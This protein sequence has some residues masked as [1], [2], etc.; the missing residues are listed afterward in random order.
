MTSSAL[1]LVEVN[2]FYGRSQALFDVGFHA[3]TGEVTC[4]VG[5]NG[6]GKTTIL[7]SIAGWVTT[8]GS[9]YL[10]S[11]KLPVKPHERAR[12]SIAYVPEDRRVFGSLTVEENLKVVDARGSSGS[13]PS[14][15]GLASDTDVF[16]LVY[17]LFPRLRERNRQRANTLSGGEQQ[18]LAVGRA[19][20][21]RPRFLLLDE[22][23]EGLAPQYMETISYSIRT[24]RELGVGVVL[25]EQSWPIAKSLGDRF[26][27]LE[28]GQ[29]V[30]G[31]DSAELQHDPDRIVNRMGV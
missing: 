11:T 22:P 23:N 24:L 18:M 29:V 31:A 12:M 26:Y 19:I 13:Q 9:I 2:A 8:T 30:D 27:L 1:E 5:L 25:V 4:L 6:M 3:F 28:N 15:S 17:E 14:D 20:V 16:S 21:A 7:R 10:D